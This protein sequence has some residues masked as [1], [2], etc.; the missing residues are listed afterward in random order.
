MSEK[1]SCGA[2]QIPRRSLIALSLLDSRPST[3]ERLQNIKLFVVLMILMI[4]T[5]GYAQYQK[6]QDDAIIISNICKNY[7]EL[8]KGSH[9][10]DPYCFDALGYKNGK[11]KGYKQDDIFGE[12]PTERLFWTGVVMI[13]PAIAAVTIFYLFLR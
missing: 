2:F 9:D 5:V 12:T 4:I 11:C 1:E 6:Y 3:E 8:C 13:T 7:P 10:F